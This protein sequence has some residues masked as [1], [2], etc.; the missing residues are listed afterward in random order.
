MKM[1]S[2][3][4]WRRSGA[5]KA[6]K[7]ILEDRTMRRRRGDDEGITSAREGLECPGTWVQGVFESAG[8]RGA[9]Q[10]DTQS[11]TDTQLTRP[12]HLA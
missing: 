2:S 11:H 5:E 9:S 8:T 12:G 6:V 10:W 1:V 3:W 4:G 7:R